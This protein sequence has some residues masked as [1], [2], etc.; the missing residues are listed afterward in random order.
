MLS[1]TK[2]ILL[3]YLHK[4]KQRILL[5]AIFFGGYITLSGDLNDNLNYDGFMVKKEV[6]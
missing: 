5:A 3:S 6:T 1:K 4:I 2:T